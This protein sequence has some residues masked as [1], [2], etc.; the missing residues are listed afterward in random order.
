M[1]MNKRKGKRHPATVA[2]LNPI[3]AIEPQSVNGVTEDDEWEEV[4]L[5]VDSGDR[6]TVIPPDILE[7]VELRQGAPHKRGVEYEV[8]NG[9]QIPNL[10]EREFTGVTAE[11]SMKS[12]VAQ[13]C[14]VNRGLLSVRKITRSGNR[15]VFDNEGSCIESK[16][17]G[18]VTKLKDDNG[19][20]EL[21]MWVKG[22][23]F[24]GK[25][26]W[27]RSTSGSVDRDSRR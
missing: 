3:V 14:D 5:A 10:G 4:K 16:T 27:R 2:M 11:G 18:E 13:V 20:Y 21:T 24:S 6:E 1:V 19:M 9:V 23:I 22:R 12:V 8:A 17:T 7:D 15:V 26:G 25:A